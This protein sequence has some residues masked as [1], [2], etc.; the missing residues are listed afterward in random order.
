MSM[1]IK[2]SEEKE[3]SSTSATKAFQSLSK[4]NSSEEKKEE[5]IVINKDFIKRIMEEFEKTEEES[6]KLLKKQKGDLEKTIFF[7]LN[8]E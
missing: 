4:S 1:N 6:E 8:S 7:I 2:V 3:I 5:K